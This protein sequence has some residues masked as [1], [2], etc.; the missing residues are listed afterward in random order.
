M[1]PLNH[2][3]NWEDYI[4]SKF[5][6]NIFDIIETK[7]ELKELEIRVRK[8]DGSSDTEIVFDLPVSNIC[9]VTFYNPQ[10]TY[11]NSE[12]DIERQRAMFFDDY[13]LTQENLEQTENYL[14]IPLY[15]GW[16][17]QCI[18]YKGRLVKSE[19]LYFDNISWKTILLKQNISWLDKSNCL[20]LLLAWPVLYIQYKFVKN[21]ANIGSPN[22]TVKKVQISPMIIVN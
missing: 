11:S 4:K 6:S 7:N 13:E 14:N 19:L 3:L 1:Q 17:E 8:S 22:V 10:S 9:R 15:Y 16:T 18:F 20:L 12:N 5:S 21:H 2:Y